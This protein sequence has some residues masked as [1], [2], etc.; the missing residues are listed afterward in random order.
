MLVLGEIATN[1]DQFKTLLNNYFSKYGVRPQEWDI[2][3]WDNKD[4]KNK[5][6]RSLKQGQSK[7]DLLITA[8][9]HHHSSKGNQEKN[10]LSELMKPK[11]VRRI[12]GSNPTKVLTAEVLIDKLDEYIN[13]K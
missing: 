3:F 12:Y 8:Q 9:I 1:K 13:N 6:L 2:D 7:Y 5:D 4:I 10:L 11:Y